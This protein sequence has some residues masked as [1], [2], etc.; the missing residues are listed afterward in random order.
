MLTK[1]LTMTTT[2][3]IPSLAVA[4]LQPLHSQRC[5]TAGDV[6]SAAAGTAV[7]DDAD[8]LALRPTGIIGS[9]AASSLSSSVVVV[10]VIETVVSFK[11]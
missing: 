3:K 4:K 6:V 2:H 9:S 1:L 10:V 5:S 8:F 7:V 11:V